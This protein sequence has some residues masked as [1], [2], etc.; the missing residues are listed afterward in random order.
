MW[1]IKLEFGEGSLDSFQKL[2]LGLGCSFIHLLC[3]KP[4]G[5]TL[6]CY[7]G[8]NKVDPRWLLSVDCQQMA[9]LNI[10][11]FVTSTT[12]YCV[13]IREVPLKGV[14]LWLIFF[15]FKQ[16]LEQPRNFKVLFLVGFEL[17]F[18]WHICMQ[19]S[20]WKLIVLKLFCNFPISAKFLITCK[21]VGYFFLPSP[22]LH[23]IF[24]PV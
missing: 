1:I 5:H 22:S 9:P 6:K 24:D 17:L 3:Q 14:T 15:N 10:T 2:C 13:F 20:K 18:W 16:T 21:I 7:W 4:D 11:L 8:I 12:F 23:I 19:T